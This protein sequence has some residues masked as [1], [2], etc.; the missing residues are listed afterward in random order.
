MIQTP[1]QNSIKQRKTTPRS[2]ENVPDCE[3]NPSSAESQGI[4]GFPSNLKGPL[5]DGASLPRREKVKDKSL[6][7]TNT[8]PLKLEMDVIL[9]CR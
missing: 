2:T 4:S 9:M 1:I 7:A 3:E 6:V 5:D 8:C